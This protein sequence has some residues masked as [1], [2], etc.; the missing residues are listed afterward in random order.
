MKKYT[1]VTES[2]S[3]SF[4]LSDASVQAK[5][6]DI[7][8]VKA[9]AKDATLYDDSEYSNEVTFSITGVD[10]I[11]GFSVANALKYELYKI[12]ED[13]PPTKKLSAPTNL[14]LVTVTVK[15]QLAT[16]SIALAS[17]GK[18][19]EITN[20]ENATSYDIHVNG[21]YATNIVRN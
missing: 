20:V 7:F 2:S 3:L 11:P 14:S 1:K 8:V 9:I 19:L 18:T 6:G 15:E 17:D 4:D 10:T 21:N 16:P 12:E 5:L 13:T